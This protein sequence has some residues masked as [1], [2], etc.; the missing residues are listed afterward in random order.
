MLPS[1]AADHATGTSARATPLVSVTRTVTGSA[2]VELTGPR[3]SSLTTV[4]R[5]F[6]AT[7]SASAVTMV[8]V[9]TPSAIT[10]RV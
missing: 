5:V 6:V 10:T 3:S 8:G 1:S 4:S 9:A 2:S 7:G